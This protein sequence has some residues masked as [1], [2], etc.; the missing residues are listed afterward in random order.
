MKLTYLSKKSCIG[1]T[2]IQRD[3]NKKKAQHARFMRAFYCSR[4]TVLE[5]L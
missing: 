5:T 3:N 1:N 2:R 4:K